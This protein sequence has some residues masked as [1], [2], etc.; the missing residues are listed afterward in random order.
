[1]AVAG[2]GFH[3]WH[4]L[5]SSF[6]SLGLSNRAFTPGVKR[7]AA[8]FGTIVAVGFAAVPLAVL[9]GLIR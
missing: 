1:M 6:S 3:L 4:G 2:L 8:A 5:Y 9:F 7:L